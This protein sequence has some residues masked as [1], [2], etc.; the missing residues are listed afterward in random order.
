MRC[1]RVCASNRARRGQS[2]R[3]C[4]LCCAPRTQ[5]TCRSP[6]S[7]HTLSSI[8]HSSSCRTSSSSSSSSSRRHTPPHTHGALC[9]RLP[10][11]QGTREVQG[12][13]GWARGCG[14]RGGWVGG[15][16]G[17]SPLR[18]GGKAKAH[19]R[20]RGCTRALARRTDRRAA[21]A[22]GAATRGGG[23]RR[24]RAAGGGR[25]P[26]SR[27]CSRW[28]TC[29]RHAGRWA[30]TRCR[31]WGRAGGGACAGAFLP[32]RA[33]VP[34]TTHAHAT[35]LQNTHNGD[36]IE[37]AGASYVV[38]VCVCG[39]GCAAGMV[40]LPSRGELS[41][42]A[43]P[44]PDTSTHASQCVVL[45][46]RLVRG[47]Y[48]RDHARLEV[49]GTSRWLRCGAAGS[50]PNNRRRARGTRAPGC[51]PPPPPSHPHTQPPLRTC[52]NQWLET[53]YSLDEPPCS[54]SSSRNSSET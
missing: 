27:G 40:V 2:S 12:A 24:A 25:R 34:S 32:A 48:T 44:Q 33:P 6:L 53:L 17:R 31:R 21:A 50:L 19:E 16:A 7:L 47:R 14:S 36:E 8:L 4:V 10:C 35:P 28:R 46:Y 49:A 54:G 38:Q 23:V 22:A 30:S 13:A 37:V 20:G 15:W 51:T 43:P 45:Q 3:V 18:T 11:Q 41:A 52:S 9:G 42:L 29:R 39:G 1:R 5:S 26:S